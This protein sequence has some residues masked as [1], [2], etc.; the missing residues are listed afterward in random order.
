M[1]IDAKQARKL[2]DDTSF[3]IHMMTYLGV[4]NLI[5]EAA[6]RGETH[7]STTGVVKDTMNALKEMAQMLEQSGFKTSVRDINYK[8]QYFIVKNLFFPAIQFSGN[9]TK[10][11]WL[12]MIDRTFDLIDL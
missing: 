12:T 2:R 4:E 11:L 6:R 10:K 1:L 3:S 9:C 8:N 7:C 5:F